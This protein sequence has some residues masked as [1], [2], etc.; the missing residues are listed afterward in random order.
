MRSVYRLGTGIF[1][2]HRREF[3]ERAAGHHRAGNAPP[4]GS[5]LRLA[6]VMSVLDA[7]IGV[8]TAQSVIGSPRIERKASIPRYD[9]SNN[10]VHRGLLSTTAKSAPNIRRLRR[11]GLHPSARRTV[12]ADCSR[13]RRRRQTFGDQN[14]HIEHA[15]ADRYREQPSVQLAGDPV[16]ADQMVLHP[17]IS[18]SSLGSTQ[19]RPGMLR[20]NIKTGK[21]LLNYD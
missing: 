3:I 21:R 5:D 1:G 11:R 13:P 8:T 7:A 17:A 10:D 18:C 12:R 2:K 20:R 4:A 16:E 14:G 19:H 15:Q 9:G 6:S